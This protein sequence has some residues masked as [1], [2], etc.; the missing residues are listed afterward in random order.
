[1]YRRILVPLDGSEVAEQVL[2]WVRL[3]ATPGDA[4]AE[5]FV[6]LDGPDAERGDG[7]RPRHLAGEYLRGVAA[8][9]L[10]GVT[11]SQVITNG[12]A[13]ERIVDEAARDEA[14][15]VAMTTH[16]RS[17]LQRFLLGSVAER[18][19][20][21]TTRPL[22]LVRAGA[23]PAAAA[24]PALR[25]LVVPLDGSAVAE[26]ALPH[27]VALA[28]AL[29]L[30]VVLVRALPAGV[31]FALNAG[32]FEGAER[33]VAE[34]V[35]GEASDYLDAVAARLRA[36][37][38]DAGAQLVHGDVAAA[39]LDWLRGVA[40]HLVVLTTRGRSGFRRLVLGSTANRLVHHAAGPV[41][42]VPA[43]PASPSD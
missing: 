7:T 37:G 33:D 6:C 43:R 36:D 20:H 15:L 26:Q 13:C 38:V 35:A 5:L 39:L 3:V 24:A 23:V 17:G 34:A 32:R 12:D 27:A 9:R 19:L 40:G 30:P 11:T 1:M 18:V 2:P 41:L 10:A 14:T 31:D 16:G 4:T 29:R 28:R 42:V 25:V 8:G 21:A 22:L